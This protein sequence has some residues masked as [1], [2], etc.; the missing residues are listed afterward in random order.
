MIMRATQRAMMS[1]AVT[2]TL[3]GWCSASSEVSSGQPCV[4]K[5]H[6]WLENQVSS[7]SSSWWTWCPPHLGQTSVSS[8]RASSQ[9]QSSQ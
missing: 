8:M 1:R 6:S 4:A 3:V 7:T 9:P 2:R 5:V